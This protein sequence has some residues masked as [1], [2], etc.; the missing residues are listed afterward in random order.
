MVALVYAVCCVVWGSTW[1]AIRVGL[2]DLPPMAFAASRITLVALLLLPS[3]FTQR[4]RL[5]PGQLTALYA[6]GV[7]QF[8][9]SFAFVFAAET[10]VD[11]GLTA[12]LF[13]TYPLFA[14]AV[15]RILL[16]EEKLST[17]H[18]VAI[19][20]GLVGLAIMHL[21]GAPLGGRAAG[22]ATLLPIGS[23]LVSAVASVATK[24]L[25]VSVPPLLTLSLNAQSGALTLW[26]LH[27]LFER[28]LTWSYSPRSVGLIAYLAV[29][30]SIVAYGGL[31]W[32]LPRIPIA[33]VGFMTFVE[34]LFSVILGRVVLDEHP[35]PSVL[36]GS[37]VVL[38]SILVAA[39][40]EWRRR[41]GGPPRPAEGS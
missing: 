5:L 28:D 22:W 31:L 33:L 11:S 20:M 26:L 7:L 30:G 29:F 15:A 39:S 2:E 34:A 6:I 35:E 13:G 3:F 25:A 14:V 12:V 16:P 23:A 41:E 40:R 1:A 9:V 21:G 37:G 17:E 24:K 36:V 8:G 10:R 38:L 27:L 4:R 32:L 19:A 18:L